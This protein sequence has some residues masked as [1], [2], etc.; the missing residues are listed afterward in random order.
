MSEQKRSTGMSTESFE[1]AA[2]K[3]LKNMRPPPGGVEQTPRYSVTKQWLVPRTPHVTEYWVEIAHD[4][5]VAQG[6]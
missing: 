5:G 4:P 2:A 1:G 3:A 6:G